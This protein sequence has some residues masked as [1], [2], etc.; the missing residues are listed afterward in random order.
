ME[1]NLKNILRALLFSTSD[2]LSIRDIQDV[3][4]RFQSEEKISGHS[5]IRGQ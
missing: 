1:F 2:V 5:G 3:I 4:M